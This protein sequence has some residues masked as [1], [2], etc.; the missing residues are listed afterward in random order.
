MRGERL[1]LLEVNEFEGGKVLG[2]TDG[3][4]QTYKVGRVEVEAGAV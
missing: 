4:T 1:Y 3:I 2:L